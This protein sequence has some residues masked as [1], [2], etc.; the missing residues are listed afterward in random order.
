MR[1]GAT[2]RGGRRQQPPSPAL[3]CTPP[4]HELVDPVTPSQLRGWLHGLPPSAGRT[5]LVGIDGFSGAGKSTLAELLADEDTTVISIEEF[6]L[7]WDGLEDGIGRSMDG[8]VGPLTRGETPRWRPWDWERGQ[9]GEPMDRPITAGVVLL[10]GCGAGAATLRV[11]QAA[12]IWVQADEDDRDRRLRARPDWA[13]YAP[14]RDIWRRQEEDLA[15]RDGTPGAADL[16][17]H[18]Q[19]DQ[20]VLASGGPLWATTASAQ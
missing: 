6:Y 17:V 15:R 13:D 4:H 9:E 20:R 8:L 5:R 2:H 18:P 7:G 3:T 10:E 11:H 16:V 12:T 1:T 14:H 19:A